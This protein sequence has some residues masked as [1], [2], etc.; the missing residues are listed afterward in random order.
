MDKDTRL[1]H[2]SSQNRHVDWDQPTTHLI[3]SVH[4]YSRQPDDDKVGDRD[5]ELMCNDDSDTNSASTDEENHDLRTKL[6]DNVSPHDACGTQ[7]ANPVEKSHDSPTK[8]GENVSSYDDTDTQSSNSHEERHE[9]PTR[10]GDTSNV[11]QH[12]YDDTRCANSDGEIGELSTTKL[13]DND[14]PRNQVIPTGRD[15]QKECAAKKEECLEDQKCF[16]MFTSLPQSLKKPNLELPPLT[17]RRPSVG[18][19]RRPS[20]KTSVDITED[21]CGTESQEN[22]HKE[23]TTYKHMSLTDKR[24]VMLRNRF[25]S[26]N[27]FNVKRQ[28]TTYFTDRSDHSPDGLRKAMSGMSLSHQRS[29]PSTG[30]RPVTSYSTS[31]SRQM[32]R[33]LPRA[34]TSS[35]CRPGRYGN[36]HF[37]SMDNAFMGLRQP[38][39]RRELEKLSQMRIDPF[40]DDVLEGEDRAEG[41][42]PLGDG[43]LDLL[44]RLQRRRPLLQQR[45]SSFLK[46]LDSFNRRGHKTGLEHILD[47]T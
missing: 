9:P 45:V 30:G 2:S 40:Q 17:S 41:W 7:S 26:K 21:D 22:G 1:D 32:D 27:L 46:D 13:D 16:F 20:I 15:T 31:R 47:I 12:D 37:S 43:Q 28:N 33:L 35:G 38:R 36:Q 19:G 39:S 18:G 5:A 23:D 14:S 42:A 29:V 10:T 4:P 24:M 6:G 25:S 3:P 44:E 11:S 8:L 34:T